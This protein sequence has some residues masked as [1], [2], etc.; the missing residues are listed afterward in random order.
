MRQPNFINN[1]G[2]LV[3]V[4]LLIAAVL[5]AYF[6][7]DFTSFI[8]S[9]HVLSLVLLRCVPFNASLVPSPPPFDCCCSISPSSNKLPV[10]PMRLFDGYFP[11]I[12][13]PLS[14]IE[15][16]LNNSP[17]SFANFMV[18]ICRNRTVFL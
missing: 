1:S 11:M 2:D 8:I 6:P 13:P 4:L 10:T 3:L 15:T 18:S 16:V 5:L 14:R 7:M 17:H 12:S 9:C